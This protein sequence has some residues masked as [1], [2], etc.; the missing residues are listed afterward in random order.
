MTHGIELVLLKCI[1]CGLPFSANED[2]VAWACTQ[3]GQGMLLTDDG[4]APQAMFWATPR[5]SGKLTWQPFWSFIGT[6]AFRERVA[7][8]SKGQPLALWQQPHRFL[9]PAFNCPLT[10]A[11]TLGADL[12]RAAPQLKPIAPQAPLPTCTLFPADA[13]AL[14]EFVVITLEAAQ[15][16]SL[17]QINFALKLNPPELWVLPFAGSVSAAGLSIA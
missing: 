14:I 16:D 2:E 5:P 10:E 8:N 1:K 6:V 11:Q 4:L 9:A 13:Q 7:F 15:R 17:K 3:C 12:L